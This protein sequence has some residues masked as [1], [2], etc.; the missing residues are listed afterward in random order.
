[1]SENVKTVLS[2]IAIAVAAPFLYWSWT[3]ETIN[4]PR[5]EMSQSEKDAGIL[6]RAC[7]NLLE[8]VLHDPSSAEWSMGDDGWYQRWP[9]RDDGAKL[10]VTAT[11]RSNNAFGVLVM[12]QYRCTADR[13]DGVLVFTGLESL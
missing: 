12:G 1:M 5:P 10:S 6:R 9:V 3:S 11:F 2:L 7:K 8:G 13:E 4:P